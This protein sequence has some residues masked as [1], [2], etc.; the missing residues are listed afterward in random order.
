[1]TLSSHRIPAKTVE[2]LAKNPAVEFDL[3]IHTVQPGSRSVIL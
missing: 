2:N 3:Y 1:M